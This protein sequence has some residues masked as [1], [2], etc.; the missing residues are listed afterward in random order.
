[1]KEIQRIRVI[2]NDKQISY[3]CSRCE[4]FS[5]GLTVLHN[6]NINDFSFRHSPFNV[7]P[8]AKLP[9]ILN[10]NKKCIRCRQKRNRTFRQHLGIMWSCETCESKTLHFITKNYVMPLT[11]DCNM[12]SLKESSIGICWQCAL[13]RSCIISE[14]SLHERKNVTFYCPFC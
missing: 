2:K 3:R 8:Y 1:M 11:I 12:V 4:R 5:N 6:Q 7:C 9:K 10:T 13:C 14:I